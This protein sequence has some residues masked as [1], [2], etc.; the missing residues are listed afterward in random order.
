MISILLSGNI[1]H[2]IP[3]SDEIC[4]RQRSCAKPQISSLLSKF[5]LLD[6]SVLEDLANQLNLIFDGSMADMAVVGISAFMI[7]SGCAKLLERPNAQSAKPV[8]KP[9]SVSIAKSKTMPATTPTSSRKLVPGLAAA[10]QLAKLNI[11]VEKGVTTA[12]AA[13][14]NQAAAS[15][16]IDA[17][18][19]AFNR[20]LREVGGVMR[21]DVKPTFEAR[22]SVEIDTAAPLV[23]FKSAIAA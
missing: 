13:S 1:R 21:L 6:S 10:A 7:V 17:A 2:D 19:L 15:I 5:N 4:G 12:R 22:R 8:Q 23:Q 3:V 20:M 14:D 18:E 11:I 16:Q 9:A